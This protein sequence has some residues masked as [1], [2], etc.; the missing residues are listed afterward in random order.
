MK[1]N[2]LLAFPVAIAILT[3][4][5]V[6]SKALFSPNTSSTNNL[7]QQDSTVIRTMNIELNRAKNF[8]RRA[9]ESANGGLGRY[10]AEDS[11]HG[12]SREAPFVDNGDGTWTFKFKGR[13]PESNVYTIESV[14]TVSQD[15]KRITVDYNGPIR[16]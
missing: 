11:M 3:L 14:V 12:P 10:R 4:G 1:L 8:A 15:G 9:A 7:K 13:R 16:N 2:I 5:A 6:P